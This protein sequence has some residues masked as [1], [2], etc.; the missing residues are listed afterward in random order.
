MTNDRICSVLDYL[1]E[2]IAAADS[3]TQMRAILA[4]AHELLAPNPV[5]SAV[6][7]L[8]HIYAEVD[9]QAIQRGSTPARAISMR[10]PS[11]QAETFMALAGRMVTLQEDDPQAF[12]RA[13][14][15]LNWLTYGEILGD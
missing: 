5:Q 10:V 12:T 14:D 6:K 1:T 4:V 3:A 15:A 2:E 9:R 8:A 7:G 11:T 13:S